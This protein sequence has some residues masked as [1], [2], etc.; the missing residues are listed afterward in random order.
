MA[1]LRKGITDINTEE[2]ALIDQAVADL[3][4]PYDICN[5]KVDDSQYAVGPEGS[6][7]LTRPGRAT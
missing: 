2:P 6:S 7:W 3:K 5:V 1:L 4:E